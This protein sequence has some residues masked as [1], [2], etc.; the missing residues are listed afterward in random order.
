M[1]KEDYNSG[2]SDTL[3][4]LAVK[5]L[6]SGRRPRWPR[7]VCQSSQCAQRSH[8]SGTSAVACGRPK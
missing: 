3:A 5:T 2:N 7:S 4:T 1:L 8:V 6:C